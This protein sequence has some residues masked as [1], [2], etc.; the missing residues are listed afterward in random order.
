M[1]D[2]VPCPNC[3]QPAQWSESNPY[4]PFCSRRCKL[5]DLGEWIEERHSIPGEPDLDGA[6]ANDGDPDQDPFV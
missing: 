3:R 4:R 1:A 2:S 6:A 5:V